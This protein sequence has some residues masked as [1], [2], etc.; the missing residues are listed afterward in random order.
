MKTSCLQIYTGN[1]KGKTTAALGL[2]LRA[3]GSGLRVY[4]GQFIKSMEY[5]EIGIL[6]SRF[7]EVTVEL[8]GDEGCIVDRDP[9]PRDIRAA[10]DG[11]SRARA[12]L[13]SGLYDLVVLDEIFIPMYFK[14]LSED[15]VLS[16]L[17]E[18][19]EKEKAGG[20]HTEL[21]LTGRYAPESILAQADLI[22]EMKE[23]RH[24]YEKGIEARDGIER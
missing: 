21:V 22:T 2:I 18:W 15:D 17:R 8:Y 7:P 5:H 3:A 19:R 12:A 6:R 4:L 13:G 23:V 9:D 20:F 24:Y 16:M 14:I 11:L 1:G 10:M